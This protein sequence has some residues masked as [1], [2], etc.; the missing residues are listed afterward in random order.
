MLDAYII[1]DIKRQ[2]QARRSE[3]PRLNIEHERVPPEVD[4]DLEEEEDDEE[5]IRIDIDAPTI[6]IG[7]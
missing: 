5:P 4:E 1:E 2:E 6:R 7:S 3:R